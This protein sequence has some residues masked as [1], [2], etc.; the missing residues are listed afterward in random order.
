ME[1]GKWVIMC[2]SPSRIFVTTELIRDLTTRP[3][4]GYQHCD[5]ENSSVSILGGTMYSTFKTRVDILKTETSRYVPRNRY[6]DLAIKRAMFAHGLYLR[7][8]A[9]RSKYSDH[10]ADT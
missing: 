5:P 6:L 1:R 10:A 7:T 3:I 8:I 2:Y 9:S 4:W